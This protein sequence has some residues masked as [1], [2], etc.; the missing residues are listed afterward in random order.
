MTSGGAEVLVIGYG[1][2]GRLDDGLGAAFAEALEG[3]ALAGVAVEVDYQLNVEQAAAIAEHRH[4][5]FVDASM[6]G[7]EPFFFRRLEPVSGSAF[8]THSLAPEALMAM[9]R[10]L[11]GAEPEGYVLGIRGYTFDGFGES[12]SPGAVE[13]MR[14]ALRFALPVLETRKFSAV[15]AAGGGTAALDGGMKCKTENA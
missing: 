8:S 2:P 7:R 3:M 12:L 6:N 14:A 11:F 1:N 15:A 9:A 4:V 13:N 5:V 10:E